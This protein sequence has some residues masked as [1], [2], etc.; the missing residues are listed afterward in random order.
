MRSLRGLAV[1]SVLAPGVVFTAASG[2]YLWDQLGWTGPMACGV[3]TVAAAGLVALVPRLLKREW[4]ADACLI[5]VVALAWGLPA[6]MVW[7]GGIACSRFGLTVVG[8]F[9]LPLFDFTIGAGG[10]VW[11]REKSHLV[12]SFELRARLEPGLE[13][14]VVANGWHGALK[15]DR[16]ALA[17]PGLAPGVTVEV[18]R[19]PEA[20]ARYNELRRAGRRVALIAHT[21]C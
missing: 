19:T 21:T 18:L 6:S 15:V 17:A 7:P 3:A 4:A 11:L 9:P 14:I 10:G 16:D 8:L 1:V 5:A 20:F 2:Q 12:T 13:V